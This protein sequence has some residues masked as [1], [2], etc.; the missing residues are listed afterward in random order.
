MKEYLDHRRPKS[1]MYKVRETRALDRIFFKNRYF[2]NKVAQIAR[3]KQWV[4]SK[5]YIF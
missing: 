5:V 1:V 4:L 2:T 3:G